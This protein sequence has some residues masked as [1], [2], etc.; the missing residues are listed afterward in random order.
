MCKMRMWW[1]DY[2]GSF[3]SKSCGMTVNEEGNYV[4]AFV[5]NVT[6]RKEMTLYYLR[7]ILFFR[8]GS[9]RN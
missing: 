3:Y 7:G 8:E 9:K 1:E 5:R 2:K 4:G 6:G